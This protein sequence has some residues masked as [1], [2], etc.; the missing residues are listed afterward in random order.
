M[1]RLYSIYQCPVIV[2]FRNFIPVDRISSV[3]N[4]GLS[5]FLKKKKVNNK[6]ESFSIFI[7]IVQ[8]YVFDPFYAIIRMKSSFHKR[9]FRSI[10]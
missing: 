10:E 6:M 9:I 8:F 2:I 1:L 5:L 3:H 7:S 4:N